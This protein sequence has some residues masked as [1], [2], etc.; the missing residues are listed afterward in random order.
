MADFQKRLTTKLACISC[1]KIVL[2]TLR[3]QKLPFLKRPR[4]SYIEKVTL[5]YVSKSYVYSHRKGQK[6]IQK[7]I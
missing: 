5:K 3:I 2:E 4:K 6:V 1:Y 7:V